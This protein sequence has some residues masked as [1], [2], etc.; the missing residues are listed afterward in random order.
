MHSSRTEILDGAPRHGYQGNRGSTISPPSIPSHL[1]IAISREVGA[2]G[3]TIGR[4]VAQRLGWAAY[5]QELLEYMAQDDSILQGL[6]ESL[7][8][9]GQEWIEQ[10]A[11]QYLRQEAISSSSD[12]LKLVRLVLALGVEGRAVL[13]G[14]GSGQILP[15]LGTL[16][17]RIVGHPDDRVGFISQSM[18][19]NLD[20]ATELMRQRDEQRNEFIRKHFHRK[21]EDSHQYDLILNSSLLGEALCADLLVQAAQ[22][23]SKAGLPRRPLSAI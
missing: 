11:Q 6:I 7:P 22:S 20:E 1:T 16:F 10:Q 9:A 4:R 5:D 2:R 14:R 13:I 3:A 15:P 17:V 21:P 18:R 8:P 12:F 19:L 23:I